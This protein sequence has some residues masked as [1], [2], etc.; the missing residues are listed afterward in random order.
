MHFCEFFLFL[1]GGT[2]VLSLKTILVLKKNG[3]PWLQIA[4]GIVQSYKLCMLIWGLEL[5]V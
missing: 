1:K 3:K 2:S 5:T 4:H